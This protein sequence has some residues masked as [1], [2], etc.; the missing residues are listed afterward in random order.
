MAQFANDG[1]DEDMT[2]K[3]L[4]VLNDD[5]MMGKQQREQNSD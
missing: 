5:D 4:P 3:Q 1:D 2:E